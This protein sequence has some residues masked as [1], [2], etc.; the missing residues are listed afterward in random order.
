M[1]KKI[2]YSFL[3]LV[4]LC[5]GY[6]FFV[7]PDFPQQFFNPNSNQ[8]ARPSPWDA[9]ITKVAPVA[10]DETLTTVNDVPPDQMRASLKKTYRLRPDSRFLTA[11]GEIHEFFTQ[12]SSREPTLE[13]QK[14]KWE[15]KY[16]DIIVGALS[17]YPDFGEFMTFLKQWVQR[18]NKGHPTNLLD[19]KPGKQQEIEN[20]LNGFYHFP[21]V[22]AAQ[23]INALWAEGGRHPWVLQA[24]ARS[25]TLLSF[26]SLNRM[27]TADII[28][29]TALAWLALA[30]QL[31]SAPM[32]RD[33]VLLAETMKYSAHAIQKSNALF[34][35]DS[36]RAYVNQD[37]QKLEKL[38]RSKNTSPQTRYFWLVRLAERDELEPW[39]L[40]F[41]EGFSPQ[42]RNVSLLKTGLEL[43]SFSARQSLPREIQFLTL[44]TVK[45]FAGMDPID[46]VITDQK[47]ILLYKLT[48]KFEKH[49]EALDNK[50]TGPFLKF[51]A[52]KAFYRENFYSSLFVEGLFFLDNLSAPKQA[53]SFSNEVGKGL[54]NWRV[55]VRRMG[56]NV[57]DIALDQDKP[58]KRSLTLWQRATH[59]EGLG[60]EF[61]I[62]YDHLVN[63]GLAK[64]NV[65]EMVNDLTELPFLGIPSAMRSWKEIKSYLK[66]GDTA[67]WICLRRLAQRLDTRPEH[68]AF[69]Y[70]MAYDDLMDMNL[71]EKNLAQL[72]RLSPNRFSAL[73]IRYWYFM[74]DQKKLLSYS[75]N[76][77]LS[78]S[79]RLMALGYLK[80]MKHMSPQI[81]L[82]EYENLVRKD[83]DNHYLRVK[84][85]KYLA[86]NKKYGKA[87]QTLYDWL[88]RD[89]P[90]GG[91][92]IPRTYTQIAQYYYDE[93][94]YPSAWKENAI[95]LKSGTGDSMNLAGRILMKLNRIEEAEEMFWN[96]YTRYPGSKS[97]A[98][99]AGYFW[100]SWKTQDATALIARHQH[101]ITSKDWT[102]IL[103]EELAEAF[104]N[105]PI[106]NGIHAVSLL[107]TAGADPIHVTGIA[108]RVYAAGNKEMAF[109]MIA[110]LSLKPEV[111]RTLYQARA[112]AYLEKYA[113][114]NKTVEWLHRTVHPSVKNRIPSFLYND[115]EY[116]LLWRFTQSPTTFHW[117]ILTASFLDYKG[118]S[119][120]DRKRMMAHY[121]TPGIEKDRYGIVGLYL[122]GRV[123][124]KEIIQRV[125]SIKKR[126]GYAYYLG[127]K[128]RAEGRMK[129]AMEWFRVCVETGMRR[130]I[131]YIYAISAMET[132]RREGKSLTLQMPVKT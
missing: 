63:S 111:E 14:G 84:F 39:S 35:G 82:R 31:T 114:T 59:F 96:Y 83:S 8:Q 65:H 12:E 42:S 1:F 16:G 62:W 85:A 45:R 102:D 50:F 107:M 113:G 52:F 48:E 24:G 109:Q 74:R 6:I 26:Q 101:P 15:V 115:N 2:L 68:L 7:D 46:P 117:L 77:Q 13:F 121:N 73:E 75:R 10:L 76:P 120:K 116:K 88:K 94:K 132:L 86:E 32:L 27:E 57:W 87:R 81:V 95:A 90:V 122:L 108:Q 124:E 110:R 51:S 99:L 11:I 9:V 5:A 71:A 92:Q 41:K 3:G 130:N 49:I 70:K 112:A 22:E 98:L 37:D 19:G 106:E 125:D 64:G 78:T 55:R 97:L 21:V 17:E 119:K 23:Q 53:R 4:S 118:I 69:M 36:L 89:V 54:N 91:L 18:L 67:Y 127:V 20:L 72:V 38:A 34:K 80:A 131:E 126:S 128:A 66:K 103:G 93:G 123:S 79:F 25:L 47:N 58:E 129:D 61:K 40:W 44:Q 43:N 60:K 56:L 104:K 105:Q 29:A 30:Q 33:E 28:P 100:K